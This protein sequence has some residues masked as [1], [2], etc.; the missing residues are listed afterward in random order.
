MAITTSPLLSSVKDPVFDYLAQTGT[1]PNEKLLEIDAFL[2]P[3]NTEVVMLS[4]LN[5]PGEY[6]WDLYAKTDQGYEPITNYQDS[7]EFIDFSP[8]SAVF[9]ESTKSIIY[10]VNGGGHHGT[11][12]SIQVINGKL[13]IESLAFMG[14]GT[15]DPN[16]TNYQKYF[17][18]TAHRI[19]VKT[20]PFTELQKKYNLNADQPLSSQ[21]RKR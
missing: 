13:S 5:S 21:N 8:E 10:L 9:D 18:A 17:G 15:K 14:P 20:T 11:L 2:G 12:R 3:K 4:T 16:W 19:T 7:V 6:I 1:F